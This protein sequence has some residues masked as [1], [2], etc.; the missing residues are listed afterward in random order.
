VTWGVVSDRHRLAPMGAL[1]QQMDQIFAARD[2]ENMQPTIDAFEQL[3]REHPDNPRLVY[4]VGGSYDTAGREEIAVGHYR[5]ALELGLDGELRRRC[6]L[7]FAS[8]LRNLGSVDESL[9]MFDEA[10]AEYPDSPS[11]GVFKALTLHASSRP[12]AA[13][14]SLLMTVVEHL[15]SPEVARYQAAIRANAEYINGLGDG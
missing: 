2:R 4:E 10:I 15:E 7:Q 3:L 14:A 8:S 12:N 11:L 1:D 13:F 9:T 5:R 6:L